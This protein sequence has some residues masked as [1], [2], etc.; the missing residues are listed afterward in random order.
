MN[1]EIR[2]E[3]GKEGG[4]RIRGLR[5]TQCNNRLRTER[6]ERKKKRK[7]R[8]GV[9]GKGCPTARGAAA[10]IRRRTGSNEGRTEERDGTGERPPLE[11]QD[12]GL[13]A[14]GTSRS[15]SG[16]HAGTPRRVTPPQRPQFTAGGKRSAPTRAYTNSWDFGASEIHGSRLYV[17]SQT[18]S[19][20]NYSRLQARYTK[21]KQTSPNLLPS[22]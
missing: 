9:T 3:R 2:G 19:S 18:L 11:G 15:W 22:A 17:P 6:E 13:A 5:H 7:K 12:R 14:A 21:T 4:D 20:E 8:I 16:H 10:R 1:K